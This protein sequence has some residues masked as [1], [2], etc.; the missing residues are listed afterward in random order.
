MACTV[1]S[2]SLLVG[3]GFSAAGFETTRNLAWRLMIMG[4]SYPA[5]GRCLIGRRVKTQSYN[6]TQATRT[7]QISPL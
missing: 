6:V 3:A 2:V 4:A 1:L 7:G 5:A